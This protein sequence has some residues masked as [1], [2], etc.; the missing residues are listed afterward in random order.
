[1]GKKAKKLASALQKEN[2]ALINKYN[3]NINMED[4]KVTLEIPYNELLRDLTL[5]I[6]KDILTYSSN[7]ALPLCEYLDHNIE[8]YVQWLLLRQK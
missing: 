6:Q 4:D 8:N 3:P 5:Q 2:E 7:N 1:M